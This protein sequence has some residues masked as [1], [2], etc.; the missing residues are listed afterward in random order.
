MVTMPMLAVVLQEVGQTSLIAV[1]V[2]ID[3]EGQMGRLNFL[4]AKC[5]IRNRNNNEHR[6]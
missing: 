6:D 1:V 3:R 4:P 5:R 2:F